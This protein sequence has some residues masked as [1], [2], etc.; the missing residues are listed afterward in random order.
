MLEEQRARLIK[1]AADGELEQ[2]NT[3]VIPSGWANAAGPDNFN[4]PH[5]QRTALTADNLEQIPQAELLAPGIRL[6]D[7][8][9]DTKPPGTTTSIP[10]QEQADCP[11]PP[12]LDPRT[13]V[14]RPRLPSSG[15]VFSV[16]VQPGSP[17]SIVDLDKS[18]DL[19]SKPSSPAASRSNTSQHSLR[20]SAMM[21]SNS[22]AGSIATSASVAES[23]TA[24][25]LSDMS[26]IS[27]SEVREQEAAIESQRMREREVSG[28]EL[29]IGGVVPTV[30]TR[31]RNERLHNSPQR[32][33]SSAATISSSP[34]QSVRDGDLAGSGPLFSPS[35]T[36]ADTMVSNESSSNGRTTL[37]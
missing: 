35:S 4:A 27:L 20:S 2:H 28:G 33:F 9:L 18:T 11:V 13:P 14:F 1:L 21:N 30:L 25:I 5:T 23:D 7:Q 32:T 3:P 36:G 12:E 10:I 6:P 34:T 37:G 8:V 26:G 29:G 22:R 15:S 24:S 16:A 17:R 31:L 19:T